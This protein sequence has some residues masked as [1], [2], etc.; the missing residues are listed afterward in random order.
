MTRII[1][2]KNTLMFKIEELLSEG[3]EVCFTPRGNSMRP[4]IEGDRD[5]VYLKQSKSVDVGDIILAKLD[6]DNF[7]CHRIID[8]SKDSLTL[9]GDGNLEGVEFVSIDNVLGKVTEIIK[10]NGKHIKPSNGN[11]WLQLL[12]IRK[13]LLWL[14]RKNLNFKL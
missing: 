7:V 4:F 14:Y 1:L 6:N 2:P 12:P 9:M 3:K 8:K 10:P 11:I 13:P 5:K